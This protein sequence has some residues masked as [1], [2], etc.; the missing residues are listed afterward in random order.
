M[1]IKGFWVFF[2]SFF[3]KNFLLSSSLCS[4]LSLSHLKKFWKKTLNKTGEGSSS[5]ANIWTPARWLPANSGAAAAPERWTPPNQIFFTLLNILF[6]SKLE[7]G[8]R[9]SRKTTYKSRSKFK[10]QKFLPLLTL[11]F[12]LWFWCSSSPFAPVRLCLS[13]FLNPILP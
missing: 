12:V 9:F 5:P 2:Y 8:Q 1:S 13:L 3:T 10:V 6:G 7:S 11:V 4:A